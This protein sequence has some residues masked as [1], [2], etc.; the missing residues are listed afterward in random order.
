MA[1]LGSTASRRT[2]LSPEE[3]VSRAS[4][5]VTQSYRRTRWLD[6]RAFVWLGA[7]KQTGRGEGASGLAFDILAQKRS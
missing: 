2:T 1:S 3:E 5:R 4:L 7:R 6:G